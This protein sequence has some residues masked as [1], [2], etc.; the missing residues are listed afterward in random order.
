MILFH[1]RAGGARAHFGS[2][3]AFPAAFFFGAAFF[4]AGAFRLTT[5]ASASVSLISCSA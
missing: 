4:L 1:V 2:G 3:F 5:G